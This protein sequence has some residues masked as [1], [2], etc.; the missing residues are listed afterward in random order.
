M[1][2]NTAFSILGGFKVK[3]SLAEEKGSPSVWAQTGVCVCVFA[4]PPEGE[5]VAQQILGPWDMVKEEPRSKSHFCLHFRLLLH[6]SIWG[7]EGEGVGGHSH[8]LI[9][10]FSKHVFQSAAFGGAT[11]TMWEVREQ[12]GT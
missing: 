1:F 12:V 7:K 9:L 5:G 8:T 11:K 2:R 10:W 3:D 6:L 4:E